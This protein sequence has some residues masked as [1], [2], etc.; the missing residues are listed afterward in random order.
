MCKFPG[1]AALEPVAWLDDGK[2][3]DSDSHPTIPQCMLFTFTPPELEAQRYTPILTLPLIFFVYMKKFFI[4]ILARG[5]CISMHWEE[6]HKHRSSRSS[7]AWE[8]RWVSPVYWGD[9][10]DCFSIS[11]VHVN[12]L[13]VL[14]KSKDSYSGDTAGPGWHCDVF[15]MPHGPLELFPIHKF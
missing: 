4:W 5:K 2:I 12:H 11:S 8:V 1:L 15:S 3:Q 7:G 10:K 9:L 13:E 6:F 14:V